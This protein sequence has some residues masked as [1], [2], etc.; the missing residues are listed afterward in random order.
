MLLCFLAAR[1]LP[2]HAQDIEPRAYS[3][4]PVG[5]NFLIVGLVHTQGGIADNP[6]L[7]INDPQLTTANA[8]F[9]YAR[10][11]D[12][13]GL[14]GKFDMIVPYTWLSGHATVAGDPVERER[15][16]PAGAT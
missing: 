12:I 1:V 11:L 10:A 14:S 2:A 15:L 4:A 16:S 3:N 8:V 13:W 9:G 6:T 7:S 5:V